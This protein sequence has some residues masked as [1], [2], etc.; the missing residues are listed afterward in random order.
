MTSDSKQLTDRFIMDG[1]LR[2]AARSLALK[3]TQ[4]STDTEVRFKT[5]FALANLTAE[6][7]QYLTPI[8]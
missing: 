1:W 8:L 6:N 4:P 3:G 7:D 5:L 2:T